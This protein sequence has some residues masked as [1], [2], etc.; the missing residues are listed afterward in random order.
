VVGTRFALLEAGISQFIYQI[1]FAFAHFFEGY[2]GLAI[3]IGAIISLAV[4]MHIT[5]K[6]DWEEKFKEK[7]WGGLPGRKKPMLN[8]NNLVKGQVPPLG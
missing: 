4:V 8:P 2:T 1:L 6:I 7:D 3:T 5:A